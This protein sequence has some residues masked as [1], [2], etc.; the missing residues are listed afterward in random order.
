[1][2][3]S[4]EAGWLDKPVAEG[5]QNGNS[6]PALLPTLAVGTIC[7][8]EPLRGLASL[9]ASAGR[10]VERKFV[11]LGHDVGGLICDP[12]RTRWKGKAGA[13]S[14][15]AGKS[16]QHLAVEPCAG[17]CSVLAD[18]NLD[19]LARTASA[20]QNGRTEVD[21]RI[22]RLSDQATGATGLLWADLVEQRSLPDQHEISSQPVLPVNHMLS[23][24]A[25]QNGVSSFV[26][27]RKAG[28][29]SGGQRKTFRSDKH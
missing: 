9:C 27:R 24:N 12:I 21:A 4:R 16:S 1:M 13:G 20:M 3:E 2:I 26:R 29:A 5:K 7:R 8:I 18:D 25:L 15:G 23:R 17:G 6:Q 10:V 11:S 19:E 14:A 28:M 22:L